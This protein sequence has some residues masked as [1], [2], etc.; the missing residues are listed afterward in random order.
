MIGQFGGVVAPSL[1]PLLAAQFGWSTA[2][3]VA[4]G[5]AVM[6]SL[7]W[8]LVNPERTLLGKSVERI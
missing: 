4:A 3:L 6:G 2:F 1:T 8:L 7:V 5:L